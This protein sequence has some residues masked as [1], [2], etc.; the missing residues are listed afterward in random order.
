MILVAAWTMALAQ[1]PGPQTPGQLLAPPPAPR[2]PQVAPTPR[3][4]TEAN[5][6]YRRGELELALEK[7]DAFLQKNATDSKA[8]FLR[9]L[10]LS[11]QRKVDD[12]IQVFLAMTQDYPELP[13][14]YNNLAVLYAG[15]GLYGKARDALTAALRANPDDPVAQEN[16]G[17]IYVRLA[18]QS[19]EQVLAKDSANRTTKGKLTILRE[20]ANNPERVRSGDP[21]LALGRSNGTNT[22]NTPQGERK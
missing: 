20:L 6:L 7:I 10:I 3:E 18:M 8:R 15:R 9:G 4:V 13:E 14:P 19:Y 21:G 11:E 5:R 22:I 12:A 2:G 1:T 16:L 17:D